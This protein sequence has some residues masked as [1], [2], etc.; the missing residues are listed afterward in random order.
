M[1]VG[2]HRGVLAHDGRVQG[3]AHEHSAG[4]HVRCC[5][6]H[7]RSLSPAGPGAVQALSS[8][9]EEPVRT[10]ACDGM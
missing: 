10:I 3:R 9:C 7:V 8:A 1:I 5:P 2:R 6:L 4:W